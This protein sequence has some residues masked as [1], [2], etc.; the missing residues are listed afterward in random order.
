MSMFIALVSYTEQGIRD[1]RNSPKRLD[2]A[3]ALLEDTGGRMLHVFMTMG[4]HDLVFVY[5]T[6]DDACAARFS[7][8]LGRQGNVRTTTMKAYPEQAYREIVNSLG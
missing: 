4:E 2:A 6:P 3:K 8:Q 5:E 7:L 1:V